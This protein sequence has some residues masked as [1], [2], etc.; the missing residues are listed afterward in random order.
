MA[1]RR[2]GSA[3]EWTQEK[4]VCV[5]VGASWGAGLPVSPQ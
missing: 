1:V 3:W 4:S 2:G 5:G